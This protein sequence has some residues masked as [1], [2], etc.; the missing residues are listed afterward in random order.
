MSIHTKCIDTIGH[1]VDVY[2]EYSSAREI[3]YLSRIYAAAYR[4][5]SKR[6]NNNNKINSLSTIMPS[7]YFVYLR[8]LISE[9]EN[10]ESINFCTLR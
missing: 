8:A 7:S 1:A 2:V 9:Q 3:F 6:A 4:S 10:Y 5:E